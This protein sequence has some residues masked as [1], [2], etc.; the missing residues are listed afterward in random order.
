[1]GNVN[2]KINGMPLSVPKDS[3]VLESARQ[4]GS[5]VR[6]RSGSDYSQT[7]V[8]EALERIRQRAAEVAGK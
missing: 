7:S 1:M 8:P 4:A 5:E 2:I 6:I 3:T